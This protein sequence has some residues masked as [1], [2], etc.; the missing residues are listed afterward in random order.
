MGLQVWV[1]WLSKKWKFTAK[2]CSSESASEHRHIQRVMACCLLDIPHKSKQ[3]KGLFWFS[4]C[5]KKE[6]KAGSKN[7]YGK[8][9]RRKKGLPQ[10]K[11]NTLHLTLLNLITFAWAHYSSLYRS[12]WI[13]SCASAIQLHELSKFAESAL[14][15]IIYVT[16]IDSPI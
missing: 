7:E 14:S 9:R 8:R 10:L 13:A 3:W 5:E 6:N 15:H 16:D 4:H 2:F 12:I 1:T 11:C